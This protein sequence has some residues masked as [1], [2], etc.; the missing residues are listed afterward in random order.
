MSG[1]KGQTWKHKQDF[2]GAVNI[3]LGAKSWEQIKRICNETGCTKSW[4]VRRAIAMYL[5]KYGVNNEK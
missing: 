4:L 2:G 3:R 1:V 5:D